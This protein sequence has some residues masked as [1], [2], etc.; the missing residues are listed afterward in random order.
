MKKLMLNILL[1]AG[2][3]PFASAQVY[4]KGDMSLFFGVGASNT[5]ATTLS[6][7]GEGA[8]NTFGPYIIGYQYHL[9]DKLTIGLA[10]THQSAS[11]VKVTIDNGIDNVSYQ[12]N[13]TFSTFLS[14]LNYSWYNNEN[15]AFV[16]YSGASV[17]TFTM[18]AELEIISGN[19]DLANKYT[20]VSE[21][22]AYHITAIGFKG[23]FTK[24]SKLGAFAEL[25]FGFNGLFN[26]GIQYTFN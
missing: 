12:T 2:I 17:G 14:Q 9:T 25:G 10:Y 19:Q 16:L 26:G 20:G 13:F 6:S 5:L 18:N 15:G 4:K 22:I 1:C 3:F 24:T 11:T 21:G 8:S 23:R 7:V